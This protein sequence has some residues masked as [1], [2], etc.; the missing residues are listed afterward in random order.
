MTQ[1][2]RPLTVRLAPD[3]HELLRIYAFV[4][5]TSLN[6]TIVRA[7]REF[8]AGTGRDELFDQ[9]V[10]QLRSQYRVALDKLADL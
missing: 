2:T 5:K 1:E 4:T 9:S 3:L 6:E 10:D 7:V 8:L